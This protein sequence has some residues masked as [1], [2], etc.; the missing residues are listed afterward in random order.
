[1]GLWEE[2][3][4][5]QT[6][7][8]RLKTTPTPNKNGS[9]LVGAC[10]ATRDRIFATGNDSVSRLFCD[11][12]AVF[13]WFQRK[14]KG[15]QLKA[16]SFQN[17]HNFSHFFRTFPPGLS[18][19]KQRVLAQRERKR[20]KDNKNNRS[21]RCCTLV[22]A[23]LSS[24]YGFRAHNHGLKGPQKPKTYCDNN[25]FSLLSFTP[26]LTVRLGP[27]WRQDLAILSP[28]GPRD[29]T[30]QLHKRHASGANKATHKIASSSL[31]LCYFSSTVSKLGAL[32]KARL[33]KVHFSGDFLG[34]FDFLRIASSLGI[35]QDNLQ[36]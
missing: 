19:S 6:S 18:P 32:W 1:M 3:H 10:L 24:S 25:M 26:I 14:I 35:P 30:C 11:A 4:Q 20:R 7:G 21:N 23:L 22:A 27:V 5:R 8:N 29:D 28:E 15:Q 13:A 9:C 16:K 34:V 31:L 17:F 36:I 33:R 12:V 2:G